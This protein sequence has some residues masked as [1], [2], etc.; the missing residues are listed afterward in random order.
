NAAAIHEA[1]RMAPADRI[2]VET[3]AP[4]LA[5][6]PHRG[7]PNEPAYVRHT[8]D[9]LAELRG[10]SLDEIAAQTTD[11]FFRLFSKAQR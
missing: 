1:A 11:N 4:Y 8:A 2:L 5:P 3:D 7:Q 10:V 9:K 6:V